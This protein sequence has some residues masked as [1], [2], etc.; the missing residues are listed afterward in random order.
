M[1][2]I[3][4]GIIATGGVEVIVIVGNIMNIVNVLHIQTRRTP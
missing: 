3:P 1:R 4:M 2:G